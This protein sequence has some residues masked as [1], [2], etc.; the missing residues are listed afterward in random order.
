M[1]CVY[2]IL[3]Y[4]FGILML[5]FVRFCEQEQVRVNAEERDALTVSASAKTGE[6]LDAFVTCLEVNAV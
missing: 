2:N 1:C 5:F 4:T 6:G 3:S